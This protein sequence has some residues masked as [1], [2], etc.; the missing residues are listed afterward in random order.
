VVSVDGVLFVQYV[1]RVCVVGGIVGQLGS[2]R[3]GGQETVQ[4]LVRHT[5]REG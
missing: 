4:Q 5:N 3:G 1:Q 2:R